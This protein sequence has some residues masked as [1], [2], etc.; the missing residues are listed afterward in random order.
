MSDM[1]DLSEKELMELA[2]HIGGPNAP[3]PTPTHNA[4]TFLH[5]VSVSDDT[6]KTGFLT[7]DE[8]GSPNLPVRTFKELANFCKEVGSMN[9]F[10]E[11][12]LKNSEI[13]TA[14]SLSREAKLLDSAVITRRQIEDVTKRKKE[15]KGWFKKKEVEGSNV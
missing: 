3:S 10:S 13:I 1:L 4:H 7:A 6:T 2:N 14:T 15:N 11:Y 5:A 8:L 12:F 9:E